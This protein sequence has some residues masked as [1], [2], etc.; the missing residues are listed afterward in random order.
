M[1][2]KQVDPKEQARQNKREI[3]RAIR[4]IERE[5]K[6]LENDQKK[7]LAEVK[8][9]ATNN[10]HNAAKIIAKNIARSRKQVNQNMQMAV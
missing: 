3:D 5:N 2:N 7:S 4:K 9:L 10:Q 6:K 8:K 1:G